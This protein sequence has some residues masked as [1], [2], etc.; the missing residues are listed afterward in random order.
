[1]IGAGLLDENLPTA[2]P[3]QQVRVTSRGEE[4]LL[5]RSRAG[6]AEVG[7]R[8]IIDREH[9]VLVTVDDKFINQ[10]LNWAIPVPDGTVIDATAEVKRLRENEA[11]GQPVTEG[12]TPTITRKRRDLFNG[13]INF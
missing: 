9:A 5:A 2:A 10:L 11:L 1:L 12:D 3:I 4:L 13:I 6:D 8:G 7:I